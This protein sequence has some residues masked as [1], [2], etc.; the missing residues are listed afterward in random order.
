MA[1]ILDGVTPE[2]V[3]AAFVLLQEHPDLLNE[4]VERMKSSMCSTSWVD[5]DEYLNRTDA[6]LLAIYKDIYPGRVTKII[7]GALS[8]VREEYVDRH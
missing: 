7:V 5:F 6:A 2:E 8:R 3:E 1:L 4:L